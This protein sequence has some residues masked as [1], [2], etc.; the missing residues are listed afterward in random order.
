MPR[1]HLFLSCFVAWLSAFTLSHAATQEVK[2]D[3]SAAVGKPQPVTL[4]DQLENL[5]RLYSDKT[6][7]IVQEFW[8]LGR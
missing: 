7:P 8:L 1:H 3:A 5:G 6:N 4:G 2:V